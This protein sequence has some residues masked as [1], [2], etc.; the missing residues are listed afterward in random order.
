MS[1]TIATGTW[2]IRYRLAHEAADIVEEFA[3]KQQARDRF[4]TVREFKDLAF[5]ELRNPGGKVW[6][7]DHW[8]DQE[9]VETR[10]DDAG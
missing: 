2:V 1:P 9:H 8:F 6:F 5:V 3:S 10:N 4:F 7:R